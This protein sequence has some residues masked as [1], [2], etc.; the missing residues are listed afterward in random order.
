MSQKTDWMPGSRT[1]QLTMALNWKNT[2]GTNAAT[3][4]I[5]PT[6]LSDL[7]SFIQAANAALTA[8]QNENTRTPVVTAQCKAAFD[9]LTAKMRDMKRRYFL[10]P[11]LAEADF[12]ASSPT[13]IPP[14]QAE[15]PQHR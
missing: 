6:V 14:P 15:P 11:P 5:P 12:V 2:A 1:G 9:A 10:G 3:W 4:G 8:A 7:D 13:T